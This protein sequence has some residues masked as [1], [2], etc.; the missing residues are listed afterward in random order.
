MRRPLLD[1]DRRPG[2]CLDGFRPDAEAKAALEH[3]PRLVVGDE[4]IDAP[5]GT[6]VFV[7]KGTPH[8]YGNPSPEPA[9]YLLV[10]TPRI[11]HLIARLHEGDW[12]DVH[13]LFR[14]HESEL[15]PP[16]AQS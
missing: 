15:L 13:E 12:K 4:T 16:S 14:E 8:A 6:T 11:E 3:V 10:M 1:E 9:R 7:E 2:R 5:A